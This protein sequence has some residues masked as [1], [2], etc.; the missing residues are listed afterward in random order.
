MRFRVL[1][2]LEVRSADGRLI[3]LGAA[4]QRTLLGMLL[5]HANRPVAVDRLINAVWPQ[6]APRTAPVALRTYVSALR[7]LAGLPGGTGP[8]SLTAT[9]G[10]YQLTVDPTHLDRLVFEELAARGSTALREGRADRAA[11]WLRQALGLWRGRPL[12][13][14]LLDA[15]SDAELTRL[16]ERRLATHEA[17]IESQLT[18]GRHADLLAELGALV[19]EQPLR[20]RLRAQWML[21]LYRSG[22]QAD[23]LHTYRDLRRHLV[24]ELGVE[25]SPPLRRL[26]HQILTGD[27][28]L[29]PPGRPARGSRVAPRQLPVDIGNFT[30][31]SAELAALLARYPSSGGPRATVISAID[32]MAGV[33]KTAL[34][35][36]AAHELADA[37]PDGQLFVDLRGFT[38]GMSP[39]DPAD[40]LDGLLRSLDVPG[41]QIPHDLDARA[42]LYRTRLA[43]RRMVILLDNAIGESQV[44]PLLPGAPGCLVLITSRARLAGLDNTEPVSLDV[45]PVHDAVALFTRC[46]GERGPAGGSADGLV[47]I[48]ELCGRLP[49]AI[50][51]AAARLR[52]RPGWTVEHLAARLRD[53]RHRLAE[54]EIG[55]LSVMS[56]IDLSY[57]HLDA[58]RQRM[59]RL[60]GLHPGP[61]IDPYAAS[62]LTAD[63]VR[64]TVR[65]LDDLVDAHLLQE[66]VPG[67]YRFH[68]L[69]RAHAA[70]VAAGRPDTGRPAALVRLFDHYAY[71]ASTALDVVYPHEAD[72]RPRIAPPATPRVAMTDEADAAAWLD[73]E[74]LNLLAVAMH[75]AGPAAHLSTSLQSHLR[76]RAH[77]GQAQALHTHAL[78]IAHTAGNL[79]DEL[80]A[81]CALGDVHLMQFQH[82]RA[83]DH[84]HRALEIA[85]ATGNQLGELN[86]LCGLGQV[87]RARGRFGP[88][89]DHFHRALDIARAIRDHDG[90]L[91]ALWS[92]GHIHGLQD[93]DGAAADCY[94]EALDIA[95]ATG[96]RLG[97]LRALTC[98][99]YVGLKR[100]EVGAATD[101]YRMTL[102]LARHVGNRNYQFEG[103]YGLGHT[104]QATGLPARALVHHQ[105]ALDIADELGQPTDRARALHGLALAH[106]ELGQP[107]HARQRWQQALDIL[108]DLGIPHADDISAEDIRAHLNEPR[109][110]S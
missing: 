38:Q 17:W 83:A 70:R 40:A 67:R 45:L 75:A 32:G 42:A 49:L 97:E 3:R 95:R 22:R 19:S 66:P 18:L 104:H 85:R 110:V 21:A 37:Y 56:A 39:V 12:E 51:I 87:H 14:V 58:T 54:F 72:Q 96:N 24:D 13:D 41:E 25:P 108:T 8:P 29:T 63:T 50:R 65:L 11:E 68:D 84:F 77:H 99:G 78:E 92:L 1:G 53:H 23:A 109:R 34:A 28:A 15:G 57:R 76:T 91:H 9:G 36:R 79:V 69:L 81:L 103:L 107:G 10:G 82:D 44:R 74:L 31:R 64:S 47:E 106:G 105:A 61:D 86:A 94:Q 88:A 4:K 62:A 46:V 80:N 6:R 101:Y 55:Q 16:D 73:A 90:E 20:E 48:V 71:T 7:R 93:R 27:P 89:A 26:H 2:T 52:A 35:V 43:D 102:D 33:G 5:L 60:L 100:G 59:Y 30:G 98:L